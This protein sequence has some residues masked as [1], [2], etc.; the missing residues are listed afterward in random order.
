MYL[1]FP[2]QNSSLK[3]WQFVEE[4]FGLCGGMFFNFSFWSQNEILIPAEIR[5]WK[6]QPFEVELRIQR[7]CLAHFDFWHNFSLSP[8]FFPLLYSHLSSTRFSLLQLCSFSSL[9]CS[10]FMC[11]LLPAVYSSLCF[12][13]VGCKRVTCLL[14]DRILTA[15]TKSSYCEMSHWFSMH[16]E[17][18]ERSLGRWA[19][20][21]LY[22][23]IIVSQ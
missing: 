3:I 14:W 8:V 16:V 19:G 5:S 1:S 20:N 9:F 12:D 21:F 4:M 2:I 11:Y 7:I 6:L 22:H 10:E 15:Q 23:S 18:T 17:M 13:T